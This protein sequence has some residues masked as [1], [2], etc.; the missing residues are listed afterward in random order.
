MWSRVC[1]IARKEK[2]GRFGKAGHRHG[3]EANEGRQWE[4]PVI[5]LENI[6]AGRGQGSNYKEE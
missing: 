3:G 2:S 4:I 5:N 6:E 1:T